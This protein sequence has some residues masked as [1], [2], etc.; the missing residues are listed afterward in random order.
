MRLESAL[1][2][3]SIV[4]VCGS[5]LRADA[6]PK[7]LRT[8]LGTIA[9]SIAKIV[10]SLGEESI[11]LGQF[12]GP[13]TM[14]TSGG[15]G[16]V[17]I[18]TEEFTKHDIRVK[19][20][21]KIG[22][23]GEFSVIEI[24]DPND[25]GRKA[26]ALEVRG[27]IVNTFGKVL[28]EFHADRVI[29][30][31]FSQSIT[32]EDALVGLTGIT[33]ALTVNGSKTTPEDRHN[34]L[35]AGLVEPGAH[36]KGKSQVC[37]AATSPYGLEVLVNDTATNVKLVDGLPYITLK[38]GDEYQIRLINSSGFD[39]AAKISI[40]GIS[41]FSFSGVKETSGPRR[42]LPAYETYLIPKRASV[43]IKGWH[44]SN[45]RVNVFTVSTPKESAAAMLGHESSVGTIAVSFMAA[46]PK[47]A[48]PPPDE[49]P[50][51]RAVGTSIGRSMPQKAD[52]VERHI[53]IIRAVVSVRYD[54]Q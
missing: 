40:D 20:V 50:T 51:R 43:S 1:I 32:D 34:Q 42:G 11:S 6:P 19:A 5:I 31:K 22:L 16:I 8:E 47:N 46:W 7:D 37:A 3:L 54:R 21:A 2:S 30:G 53:G 25:R 24:D 29:E 45:Q 44:H 10:K 33:A 49:P 14:P 39:A 13:P 18:F 28:T 48:P 41:T 15:S 27:S 4:L 12:T 36:I 17:Q 52:E 9:A 35:A 23:K 26:L 38:E